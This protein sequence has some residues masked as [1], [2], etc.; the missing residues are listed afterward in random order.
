MTISA[1]AKLTEQ[2]KVVMGIA[3]ILAGGTPDYVSLKGYE[4]MAIILLVDNGAVPTGSAVTLKQATDVAAT[5]EKPLSFTTVD[6]NI[7]TD[8]TDTLVATAVTSDTFTTDATANKNL[9]YVLDVTPDMLD[10]DNNFDCVRLGTG[11][12]VAAIAS[13][14]YILT[15]KYPKATPLSAIL[16]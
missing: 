3:P 14:A 6:A 10:I 8:A 7:D 15:A 1:N 5:G 16:D 13:V 2:A 11:T 12:G 4:R 9:M